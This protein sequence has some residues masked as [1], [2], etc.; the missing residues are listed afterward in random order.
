MRGYAPGT[1]RYSAPELITLGRTSFASDVYAFGVSLYE[2]FAGGAH[3]HALPDDAPVGDF[4]QA[5]ILKAPVPLRTLVPNLADDVADLVAR[6][7]DKRPERRPGAREL[8]DGLRAAL[9]SPGDAEALA[10]LRAERVRERG[11]RV[12]VRLATVGVSMMMLMGVI[13]AWRHWRGAP[14]ERPNVTVEAPGPQ[15]PLA[16]RVAAPAA[17]LHV[18]WTAPGVV[19]VANAGALDLQDVTVRVANVIYPLGTIAVDE[20]TWV[21]AAGEGAVTVEGRAADGTRIV[22]VLS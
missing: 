20:E 7:L 10:A 22:A 15:S 16:P 19:G 12:A 13:A 3:P 1:P 6:A 21:F 14:V 17:R 2:L 4:L 5:H 18:T 8:A 11:T 9:P